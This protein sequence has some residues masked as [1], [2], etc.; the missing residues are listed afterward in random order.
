M[1]L[2]R[3]PQGRAA[4]DG[5]PTMMSS[6]F[7]MGIEVG[8]V[9][10]LPSAPSFAMG[11]QDSVSSIDRP[12]RSSPIMMESI[13]LSHTPT[14]ERF[15]DLEPPTLS[16]TKANETPPDE[17]PTKSEHDEKEMELAVVVTPPPATAPL[18]PAS[19]TISANTPPSSPLRYK[20]ADHKQ[21]SSW[22]KKI[23][24]Q[25][26]KT[27]SNKTTTSDS[28]KSSSK[29]VDAPSTPANSLRS[30]VMGEPA[31]QQESP[32]VTVS[33]E[34]PEDGTVSWAST[35]T[36]D[37]SRLVT[38]NGKSR[39]IP[40]LR[41]DA[42]PSLQ[43]T[44]EP[45]GK[46]D[47]H[48]LQKS[49]GETRSAKQNPTSHL[50]PSPVQEKPD[51]PLPH[52]TGPLYP[53]TSDANQPALNLTDTCT[54]ATPT[55][56]DERD[57]PPTLRRNL[58]SGGATEPSED[59][60][61]MVPQPSVS[62]KSDPGDSGRSVSALASAAARW[63][64]LRDRRT[65]SPQS[66]MNYGSTDDVLITLHPTGETFEHSSHILAYASPVLR[67]HLIPIPG[68]WYR[69]ELH[70]TSSVEWQLILPFLEPHSVQTAVVRPGNLSHLLP[71]FV[72]LGLDVLIAEC[73]NL[74]VTLEFPKAYSVE[75]ASAAASAVNDKKL[76]DHPSLPQVNDMVDILL[77]AEI[78]SLAGLSGTRIASLETLE[79]YLALHP[80]LAMDAESLPIL[81]RLIRDHPSIRS[82]LWRKCLVRF[83]PADL[84][85]FSE[86]DLHTGDA[87]RDNVEEMVSNP[88]FPFLLRE[89]LAKAAREDDH[90]RRTLELEERWKRFRERQSTT[91]V[92]IP[93]NSI[94]ENNAD[95][96]FALNRGET[97]SVNTGKF[98]KN[99]P[100]DVCLE[101]QSSN[102][103]A[104]WLKS[105]SEFHKMV[106][107]GQSSKTSLQESLAN[108][109][110][111]SESQKLQY[112]MEEI[113]KSARS[114]T[115]WLE[116]ILQ[117]L[118]RPP[119]FPTAERETT[120]GI[121]LPRQT[122]RDR[123]KFLC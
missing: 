114:R 43:E 45:Q 57:G 16:A 56:A 92:S 107:P 81:M 25:R 2:G 20:R 52:I 47:R 76:A 60:R 95:V 19:P 5:D 121:Y 36:T 27:S 110:N 113:C 96:S 88:L 122:A 39:Q 90:N 64:H 77:L 50:P 29:Q 116:L 78:S 55:E 119:I 112:E 102:F 97:E 84:P 79:S 33:P 73:D 109:R 70:Q 53:Y 82:R 117:R 42:L 51:S 4:L 10:F 18:R 17:T 34:S 9:S 106:S 93:D 6:S 80:R 67:Q 68:G 21:R 24:Q 87:D 3:T 72:Q 105:S 101:N 59:F 32:V 85:I 89:G 94:M 28:E 63:S 75:G 14:D 99:H 120:P 66:A 37:P 118:G 71:W 13:P 65:P 74:L 48:L 26:R 111:R 98:Q 100:F 46:L 69:L 108:I 115:N 15:L 62:T 44:E 104:W 58:S 54:D 23:L 40:Y 49:V 1:P 83:L 91:P 123:R 30:G 35:L 61:S 38:S 86:G 103:A 22:A 8:G 31:F 11:D 12:L 41:L 7:E